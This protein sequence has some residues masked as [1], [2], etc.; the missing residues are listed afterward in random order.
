VLVY[1][2]V[3]YGVCRIIINKVYTLAVF[4]LEKI[5]FCYLMEQQ[6]IRF[7]NLENCLNLRSHSEVGS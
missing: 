5:C 2:Q 7:S 3:K 6:L 1:L 4:S